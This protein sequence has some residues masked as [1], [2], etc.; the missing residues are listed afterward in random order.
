MPAM[1]I[2][3]TFRPEIQEALC[4]ERYHHP[5]SLVQ[6]RM[7]VLWLKNH[8]L[9]HELIARP[10]GVSENTMREL[11]RLVRSGQPGQAEI[12]QPVPRPVRWQPTPRRWR[13]TFA[14]SRRRPSKQSSMRS[15][16]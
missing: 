16:R 15:R 11:F 12:G 14:I 13:R 9:A 6:R 7:E 2:Q 1:T 3:L 5:V 10:A 4:Y 8:G